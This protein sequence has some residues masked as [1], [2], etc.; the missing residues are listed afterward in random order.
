MALT[1]ALVFQRSAVLVAH[2]RDIKE[3]RVIESLR[4]VILDG[5]LAVQP[6]PGRADEM[7]LNGFRDVDRPSRR[8]DNFGVEALDAQFL[9]VPWRNEHK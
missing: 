9:R 3:E 4:G 7:R 6:V 5:D 1:A 2:P 8:Y